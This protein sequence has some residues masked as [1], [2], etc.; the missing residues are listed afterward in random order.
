MDFVDHHPL[1]GQPPGREGLKAAV[2]MVQS[3]F[4]T[5]DFA[6]E[7]VITE[8]DKVVD[9]WTTTVTHVGDFLGFPATGKTATFTGIDIHRVVGGKA[10]EAWHVQDIA[11]LMQQL[12]A[13][14][15]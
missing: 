4:R 13:M 1:P 8:G 5:D 12:G 15:G 6:L 2:A 11:G 10:A 7:D 3:T 14:P 9:R